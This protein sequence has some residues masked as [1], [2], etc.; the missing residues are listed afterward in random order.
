[1]FDNSPAL[2][3]PQPLFEESGK[4]VTDRNELAM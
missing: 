2:F 3:T 1:M 4:S